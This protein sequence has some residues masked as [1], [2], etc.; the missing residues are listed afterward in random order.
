MKFCKMCF[1]L[2]ETISNTCRLSF[3]EQTTRFFDQGNS[4][5][6]ARQDFGNFNKII[7]VKLVL[8]T[9]GEVGGRD[10]FVLNLYSQYEFQTDTLDVTK[11][12]LFMPFDDF[13][14][15][16]DTTSGPCHFYRQ[17]SR[18]IIIIIILYTVLIYYTIIYYYIYCTIMYYYNYIIYY[19]NY[20]K[21]YNY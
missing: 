11:E 3:L 14:Y 7:F 9:S 16:F 5:Q 21:S 1:F 20:T 10:V 8:L 19:K 18:R 12:K 15:K 17:C 6:P 4:Q 13:S 2:K